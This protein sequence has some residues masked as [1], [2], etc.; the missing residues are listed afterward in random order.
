VPH[1]AV[2]LADRA[3]PQDVCTAILHAA[4]L[5]RCV[6]ERLEAPDGGGRA[7]GGGGGGGGSGSTEG[8]LAERRAAMKV[9]E[10]TL[11][12]V[13]QCSAEAGRRARREAKRFLKEVSAAGWQTQRLLLSPTE[14]TGYS[15][16]Q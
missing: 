11:G 5:R 16:Q 12:E 4:H 10:L 14:R 3:S 9:A 15:L 6:V 1:L 7:G 8:T 2:A 13:E